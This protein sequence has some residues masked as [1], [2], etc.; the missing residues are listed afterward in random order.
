MR[1]TCPT[2]NEIKSA[3]DKIE[4]RVFRNY[5]SPKR[6]EEMV[7]NQYRFEHYGIGSR[8]KE[9][10][11]FAKEKLLNGHFVTGGYLATSIRDYHDHYI[12]WKP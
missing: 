1:L 4:D 2:Q 5:I 12:I 3:L 8:G 6:Y 11:S 9:M 10:R 7:S